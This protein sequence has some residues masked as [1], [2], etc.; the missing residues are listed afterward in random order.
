MQYKIGNRIRKYREACN[1]SQK[2]LAEKIN[3]S[4]SRVS[5]WEQGVNRPDVDIF[6]QICFALKVS[7]SE[8]LDVRLSPDDLND[9]ERAVIKAYRTKTNLQSAVCILLGVTDDDA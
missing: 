4:S 8:L 1:M 2:V 5:N 3:V 7:P 9:Q 6:V